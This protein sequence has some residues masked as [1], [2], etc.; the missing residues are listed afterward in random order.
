MFFLL[1][2]SLFVT[3][4]LFPFRPELFF[5]LADDTQ[6]PRGWWECY[7]AVVSAIA[8]SRALALLTSE[9]GT[10]I[11]MEV[12]SRLKVCWRSWRRWKWWWVRKPISCDLALGAMN[13]EDDWKG[14]DMRGGVR[15]WISVTN[16]CM[17]TWR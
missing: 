6:R 9:L 8:L 11:S 1:S 13:R 10:V 17:F 15:I 3:K 7:V 4:F 2:L 14:V 5:C 16:M 12:A